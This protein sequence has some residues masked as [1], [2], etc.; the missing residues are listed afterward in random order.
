MVS[1]YPQLPLSQ[2]LEMLP[3]VTGISSRLWWCSFHF[4]SSLKCLDWQSHVDQSCLDALAM[5]FNSS[6]LICWNGIALVS[7]PCNSMQA[8]LFT[9]YKKWGELKIAHELQLQAF[10]GFRIW[11][12]L[13]RPSSLLGYPNIWRTC[14]S[15]RNRRGCHWSC[16]GWRR[17]RC[18][19]NLPKKFGS[20][21]SSKCISHNSY[22]FPMF[23]NSIE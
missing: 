7:G 18:L 5:F 23:C 15:H 19:K 4:F 14:R 22:H 9:S 3:T 12:E 16:C 21:E 1:I 13:N 10:L 8:F 17:S 11:C 2:N 6:L 20:L